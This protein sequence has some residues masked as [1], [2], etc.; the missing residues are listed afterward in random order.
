MDQRNRAAVCDWASA[1]DAEFLSW[2]LVVVVA[3]L[4]NPAARQMEIGWIFDQGCAGRGHATEAAKTLLG[5][6]LTDK[7]AHRVLAR[8]K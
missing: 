6:L 1:A 5:Y 7:N 3:T 8:L 4:E 2:F